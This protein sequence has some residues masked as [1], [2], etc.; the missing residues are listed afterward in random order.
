MDKKIKLTIYILGI[1]FTSMTLQTWALTGGAP[2]IVRF[3]LQTVFL[4]YFIYLLV[5]ILLDRE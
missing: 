1:I 5:K 4:T 3:L 2:S